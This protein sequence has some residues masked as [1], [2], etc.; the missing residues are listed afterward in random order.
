[1]FVSTG[2]VY[3]AFDALEQGEDS[4]LRGPLDGDVMA[5]MEIYGE[6]KVA[7]EDG[8]PTRGVH[9]PPSCGPA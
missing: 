6:A 9:R 1:M 4:P 2:N 8:R 7:C 5:D 3:A